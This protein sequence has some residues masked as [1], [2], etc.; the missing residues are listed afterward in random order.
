MPQA[1][2][3]EQRILH[4][5]SVVITLKCA[6]ESLLLRNS[7]TKLINIAVKTACMSHVHERQTTIPVRGFPD[8]QLSQTHGK[9]QNGM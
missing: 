3:N 7:N 9:Q 2:A 8:H 4:V 6:K 1:V 5:V